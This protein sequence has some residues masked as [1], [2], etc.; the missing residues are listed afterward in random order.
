VPDLSGIDKTT[1]NP[2][3]SGLGSDLPSHRPTRLE[4]S[5][6]QSARKTDADM[7]F[8]NQSAF[9]PMRRWNTA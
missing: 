1:M 4:V 2:L 6:L 3:V 9:P 8:A 5:C 7:H